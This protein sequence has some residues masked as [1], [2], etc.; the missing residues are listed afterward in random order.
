MSGPE[1]QDDGPGFKHATLREVYRLVHEPNTRVS[2]P[3][4]HLSAEY[5][6]LFTAEAV[7]RAAQVATLEQEQ[8]DTPSSTLLETRHLE[9]VLAGMMLDF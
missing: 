7:H 6:K 8:G 9:K 4:L 2:A 5:L 3:A 1:Q